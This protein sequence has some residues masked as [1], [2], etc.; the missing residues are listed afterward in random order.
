MKKRSKRKKVRLR[1]WLGS[2]VFAGD[3]YTRRTRYV[4]AAG[5]ETYLVKIVF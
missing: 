3:I 1:V 4:P 2:N 5:H